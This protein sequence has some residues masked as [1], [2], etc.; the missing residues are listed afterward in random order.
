MALCMFIVFNTVLHAQN[1]IK[2]W[3]KRTKSKEKRKFSFFS[4]EILTPTPAK[5]AISTLLGRNSQNF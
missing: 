1:M 2:W 3:N 4:H 5:I